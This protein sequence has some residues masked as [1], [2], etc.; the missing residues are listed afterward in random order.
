[1]LKCKGATR[2]LRSDDAVPQVKIDAAE[3]GSLAVML[4]KNLSSDEDQE[5]FCE[6]FSEDLI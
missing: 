1:M 4:F 2:G 6:G 3:P 5:Y